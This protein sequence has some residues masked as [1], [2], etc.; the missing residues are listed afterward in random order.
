CNLLEL[1]NVDELNREALG[2]IFPRLRQ[3]VLDVTTAPVKRSNAFQRMSFRSLLGQY[4]RR[5]EDVLNKRASRVARAIA[6]IK[7]VIG[8]G[9]FRGLGLSHRSGSVRKARLFKPDIGDGNFE[10]LWRLVRNKLDSF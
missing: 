4:L 9:S 1:T 5:D 6:M 2:Q 3:L 7:I 8:F 10:L